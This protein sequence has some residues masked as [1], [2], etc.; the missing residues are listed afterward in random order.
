M[1]RRLWSRLRRSR[2]ALRRGLN[3]RARVTKSSTESSG[4]ASDVKA[5][6]FR[7]PA[8]RVS[9]PT[10]TSTSAAR[11]HADEDESIEA[12][13]VDES[14]EVGGV[15]LRGVVHLRRP[16]AV[17]V[18]PLVEGEAV[19]LE[20]E[21]GA[22]E[23]PG[24]DVE[25]APVQEEHRRLAARAPVEIVEAHPSQDDVMRLGQ[26]QLGEREPG[27]GRRQY[28]MLAE[29]VGAQAHESRV[30][31]VL[32]TITLHRRRRAGAVGGDGIRSRPSPPPAAKS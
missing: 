6:I 30:R 2:V 5:A 13:A 1:R 9:G 23:V 10:S 31:D 22:D 27:G 3:A 14:V 4:V 24:V 29:L 7:A 12:E 28:Q 19:P 17:A 15:A 21:R 11:R 18:A 20:P 25:P 32:L 26:D 8:W 16:F